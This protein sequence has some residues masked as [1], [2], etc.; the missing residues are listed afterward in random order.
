MIFINTSE[1][2][3]SSTL[4][5][6]TVFQSLHDNTRQPK[7]RSLGNI[8]QAKLLAYCPNRQR[9]CINILDLESRTP[10]DGVWLLKIDS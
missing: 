3:N 10:H 5:E 6:S 1:Y 7:M 2:R 9:A 4:V 8:Y